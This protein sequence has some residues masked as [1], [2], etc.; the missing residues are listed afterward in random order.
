M[1][2]DRAYKSRAEQAV[3]MEPHTTIANF[4][5]GRQNDAA[6]AAEEEGKILF[7]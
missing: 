4:V 3:R 6:A 5:V 2:T 1:P 7:L